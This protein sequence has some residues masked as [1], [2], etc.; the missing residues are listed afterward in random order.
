MILHP[1]AKSS[2]TLADIVRPLC[3]TIPAGVLE[4]LTYGCAGLYGG[5][6]CLILSIEKLLVT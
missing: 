4:I 5:L 2:S 3:A 6:F 1:C